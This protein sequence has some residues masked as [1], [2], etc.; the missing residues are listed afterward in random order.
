MGCVVGYL[1]L[2]EMIHHLD[3]E[4]VPPPPVDPHILCRRVDHLQVP[5]T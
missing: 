1:F 3:V 2:K 4:R 5:I